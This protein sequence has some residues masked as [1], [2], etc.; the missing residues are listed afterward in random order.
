MKIKETHYMG[1]DWG[2]GQALVINIDGKDVFH[3][4]GGEPEDNSLDRDLNFAFDIVGEIE[5][6]YKKGSEGGELSV[7]RVE[8]NGTY[9]Y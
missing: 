2:E 5:K 4:S 7:E 1:D 3:V 8:V 6:A 9:E